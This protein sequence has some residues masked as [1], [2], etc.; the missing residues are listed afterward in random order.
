MNKITV[1]ICID[2]LDPEYLHA[3][4]APNLRALS[5]GGFHKTGHCMMPSVTNVNNVSLVTASYPQ[6]HGICSNF[7]LEHQGSEGIYVES[8]KYILA[9]TIFQKVQKLGKTS[10]LVTSKDKLR[11]LLGESATITVSSEQP[12]EWVVSGVGAP[13]KIYSL[14]V[15]GW[16]I[17]AASY[18]MARHPADVVYITTTDYAMHTYGPDHSQSQKHMSILDDAIGEL[19]EAHPDITLLITADHGM[20]RKTQMVNLRQV[21][22][23]YGIKANP[24]PII[25]DRYVAHHSNL[26]G[27]IFIY[28]RSSDLTEALKVLRETSGVE[29]ALPRE[30]AVSRFKLSYERIGDIVVTGEKDVVFGDPTEVEMPP[31]LR[32]HGSTHEGLVPLIG[33]NGDF[34]GFS[35]E[36]NRDLGRY[37]FERSL[38]LEAEG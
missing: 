16:V 28:L 21:L 34:S 8:G 7:W 12:P 5:R 6:V 38:G 1:V 24:V 26:G 25:K 20:S 22:E 4:E 37:I 32:S 2:G 30:E 3:C 9:E 14:E 18:I 36:E 11:T 35:F 19:V 23:G 33:Y 27:C 13:P 31:T 15:N 17:K 10:I 29:E